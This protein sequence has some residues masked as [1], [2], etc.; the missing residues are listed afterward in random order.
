VESIGSVGLILTVS[1]KMLPVLGILRE[2]TNAGIR[3][4][5]NENRPAIGISATWDHGQTANRFLACRQEPW[6]GC[7]MI[8]DRQH[9]LQRLRPFGSGNGLDRL[10]AGKAH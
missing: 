5:G 8:L 7:S 3:W 4:W 1:T 6:P 10:G 2:E 9:I